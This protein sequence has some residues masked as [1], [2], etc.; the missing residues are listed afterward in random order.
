MNKSTRMILFVIIALYLTSICGCRFY[1]Y[2]PDTAMMFSQVFHAVPGGRIYDTLDIQGKMIETDEY[3]RICFSLSNGRIKC[4]CIM[5]KHDDQYVYYYD[6]VSFLYSESYK[7]PA[8]EE[9]D[10]LKAVNDWN[11]P[12]DEG[13]MIK[14][15]LVDDYSLKPIPNREWSNDEESAISAF[16]KTIDEMDCEIGVVFIDYSQNG[17]ELFV[18]LRSELI[19][20][21]TGKSEW[22]QIDEYFIVL[23][24]DG[25]YDPENYLLKLDYFDK[26]NIPSALAEIKERNGWVG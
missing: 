8:T 5:Q 26:S 6:N 14:R 20:G 24:A 11:E 23:N 22:I 4:V 18:V 16:H 7:G 9:I 17:Q 12:M 10:E 21:E 19:K 1:S 2:P 3:G 25:T 15:P 13:K